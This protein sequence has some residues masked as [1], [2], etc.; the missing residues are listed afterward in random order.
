MIT[1]GRS[2]EPLAKSCGD[3]T[4]VPQARLGKGMGVEES[5]RYLEKNIL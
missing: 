1:N 3:I 5:T 4:N 2:N